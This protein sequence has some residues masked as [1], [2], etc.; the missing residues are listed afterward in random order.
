MNNPPQILD[1]TYNCLAK[2]HT[3]KFL[4]NSLRLYNEGQHHWLNWICNTGIDTINI[5]NDLNVY[6][7]ACRQDYLGNIHEVFLSNTK[8]NLPKTPTICKQNTCTGCSL[9][10][11]T[12]KYKTQ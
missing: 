11:Q 7:G 3:K 9:D 4:V 6:N 10:L 2:T 8:L 1:N 12:T 5:D